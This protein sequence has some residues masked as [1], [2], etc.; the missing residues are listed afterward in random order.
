M[1]FE[2]GTNEAYLAGVPTYSKRGH[3]LVPMAV[4]A[5]TIRHALLLAGEHE[6]DEPGQAGFL[7]GEAGADELNCYFIAPLV[8]YVGTDILT[9]NEAADAY[10]ASELS[11]EKRDALER[12]VAILQAFGL[13]ANIDRSFNGW[14]NWVISIE[15]PEAEA[16]YE[17]LSKA[18][19]EH[20]E[21]EWRTLEKA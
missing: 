7:I 20:T 16:F 17:E 6:W 5:S 8:W 9:E 3:V 12:W 2:E 4:P 18:E 19:D 15:P 1:Q 21:D 11:Q 13:D 14:D 10:E